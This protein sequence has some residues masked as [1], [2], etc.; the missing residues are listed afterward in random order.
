MIS[1]TELDAFVQLIMAE[2]PEIT[3]YLMVIDEQ[4]TVNKLKSLS[5]TR[6]A[7]IY[8]SATRQGKPNHVVDANSTW[9]F[10]LEKDS[11]G[12]TEAKELA[13]M[14]KLQDIALKIIE[15]IDDIQTDGCSIVD[16]YVPGE[17]EINP[18]YRS[19]GGWNGW[20]FGLV[21]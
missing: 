8:P 19:F 18:E 16:R 13:Q 1:V 17:T 5:G 12:Q 14:Q 2:V 10:V 21:F 11:A 4:H 3:G 7:V 20:S 6:L 15:F 9:F